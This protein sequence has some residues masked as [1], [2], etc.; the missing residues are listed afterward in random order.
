MVIMMA[1]GAVSWQSKKQSTVATSTT[2]AEY[3]ACTNAVKE[4]IWIGNFLKELGR[5]ADGQNTLFSDNQG[6]IALAH[7]PEFHARTK[8]IDIQH[9]FIRECVESGQ[10]KLEYCP[11][12]DMVA[13]ALT[14]PLPRE[15]HWGMMAKMGLESIEHFKSGSV[16]ILGVFNAKS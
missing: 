13:D 10:V 15:K 11:T 7:N 14:K 2:E 8:H 5:E 16:G 1:K 4:L 6:A 3:V 9:H 12:K